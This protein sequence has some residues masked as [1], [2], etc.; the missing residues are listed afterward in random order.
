M[1][2]R[3]L[4]L[5]A[6]VALV[7]A[8]I[9]GT[10]L[11]FGGAGGGGST[12]TSLFATLNGASEI[13]DTGAANA[14]DLN[15]YG[16]ATV[17]IQGRTVCVAV[18]VAKIGDFSAGHIHKGAPGTNGGVT[19]DLQLSGDGSPGVAANCVR[20]SNAVAR[21]LARNPGKYYVNLHNAAYPA[22]AI[23]GQTGH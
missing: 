1:R 8:G 2:T 15:G 6:L 18:A 19:I 21:D 7:S 10:V 20:T 5:A 11:A 17:T 16:G 3:R 4:A 13:S 22:G 23:R 9:F 12:K 14:G